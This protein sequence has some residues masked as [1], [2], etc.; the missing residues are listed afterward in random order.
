MRRLPLS[1]PLSF[2]RQSGFRWNRINVGVMPALVAGINAFFLQ[3]LK[4]SK[5]WMAA[6]SRP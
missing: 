3:L 4:L 1:S 5:T 6:T 2:A